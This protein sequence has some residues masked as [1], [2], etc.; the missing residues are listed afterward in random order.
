MRRARRFLIKLTGMAAW[1]LSAFAAQA[2]TTL[3]IANI[4]ELALKDILPPL[5]K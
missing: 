5:G 4:V 3:K 2:Q 1:S